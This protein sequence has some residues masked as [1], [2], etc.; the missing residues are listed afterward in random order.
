M[1]TSEPASNGGDPS[2]DP[3]WTLFAV[4]SLANLSASLAPDSR[5]RTSGGSGPQWRVLFARYDPTGCCWRTFQDCLDGASVT[6]SQT[7]PRAGMTQSGI[8]YQ[9]PPSAPLTSVTG[10][11]RWPTPLAR[12]GQAHRVGDPNRH[13]GS[14][15]NDWAAKWPTPRAS[16]GDKGGRGDLLAMVRTGRDSRRK[17]WPNPTASDGMGGPGSSGREGGENLRTAVGGQLNPTWVEALMGFPLGWTE[18]DD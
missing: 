18:L 4:D 12:T 16:D 9:L 13:G 5:R 2:Q 8:A 14:N 1:T 10:S 17:N 6:W 11:S 3:E 7:W 15:P